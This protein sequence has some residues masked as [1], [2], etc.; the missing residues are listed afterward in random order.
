MLRLFEDLGAFGKK[1]TNELSSTLRLLKV[2]S[3]V[4]VLA[5]VPLTATIF[6]A[7]WQIVFNIPCHTINGSKCNAPNCIACN[8]NYVI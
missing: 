2:L 3:Q 4:V 1:G 7:K 5:S 6:M 8:D